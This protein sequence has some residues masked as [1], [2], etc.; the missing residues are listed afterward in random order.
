MER[1]ILTIEDETNTNAI[2]NAQLNTGSVSRQATVD[3]TI[4]SGIMFN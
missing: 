2:T 1:S 4:F 3:Y